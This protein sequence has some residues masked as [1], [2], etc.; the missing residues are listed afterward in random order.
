M[1]ISFGEEF[2]ARKSHGIE[3]G[4]KYLWEWHPRQTA[5]GSDRV[6]PKARLCEP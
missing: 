4:E 1:R 5:A 6:K 3:F 2:N